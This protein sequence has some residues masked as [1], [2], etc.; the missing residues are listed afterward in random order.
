MYHQNRRDW[1]YM[2]NLQYSLCRQLWIL[3]QPQKKLHRTEADE[4]TTQNSDAY[5]TLCIMD[6]LGNDVTVTHLA[7]D[8][9]CE[10]F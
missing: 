5:V 9:G 6:P 7:V 1:G 10:P 2:L 4:V 3:R 8:R